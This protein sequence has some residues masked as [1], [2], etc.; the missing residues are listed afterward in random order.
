[1]WPSDGEEHELRALADGWLSVG[2][3]ALPRRCRFD[4][5]VDGLAQT[6]EYDGARLSRSFDG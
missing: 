4:D 2:D 1:M 3:P 6:V 5:V